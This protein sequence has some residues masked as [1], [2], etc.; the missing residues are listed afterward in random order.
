MISLQNIQKADPKKALIFLNTARLHFWRPG[1]LWELESS[2]V[3]SKKDSI[4][5]IDFRGGEELVAGFTSAIDAGDL[6]ESFQANSDLGEVQ[7]VYRSEVGSGEGASRLVLQTETGKSR[8]ALSH[9]QKQFPES[10][11]IEEG[12]SN[13][14]GSVSEQIKGDAILSVSVALLGSYFMWLFVS[15]WDT[16]LVQLCHYS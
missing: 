3:Y 15:K 4:L 14:G 1:S 5:G 2:S 16:P 10:S 11:F 13:I 7:H 6:E 8:E 9:L 12:L